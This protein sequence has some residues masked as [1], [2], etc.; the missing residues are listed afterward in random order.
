VSTS[1]LNPDVLDAAHPDGPT[2]FLWLEITSSCQLSCGHCYA[3][4]GPGGSHGAMTEE[5]WSD[6]I[7]SAAESGVSMIQFIG[8][9]PTTHAAF[10]RLVQLALS[11]GL[12]VEVFS[13]LFSISPDGWACL[14]LPG[15]RLATSYYSSSPRIHDRITNRLGS[16]GRTLANI[17]K[18]IE[19]GIPLRVGL[20]RVEDD[21]DVDDARAQLL[22]AGVPQ[23]QIRVDDLRSVG[24][25]A[26]GST[27]VARDEDALCGNCA[28]GVAAILPDGSV[29]PCVFSRQQHFEVGNLLDQT[30]GEVLAGAELRDL[31]GRLSAD[32]T[33]RACA[34]AGGGGGSCSPA[35]GG[36]GP[37]SPAGVRAT[38]RRY[39]QPVVDCGP[40]CSPSCAPVGN[41]NPIVNPGPCNPVGGHPPRP[42]P[43]PRP[44]GPVCNPY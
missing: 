33:A 16:H 8:G 35:G 27:P 28:S 36:G 21:Q 18:A 43:T 44:D 24:R 9:E 15:V 12:E 23:D 20:I 13:N 22:T 25:G 32:F 10:A 2:S 7:R 1:T 17:G 37:C 34:P 29:H 30:L 38:A 26:V 11:S 31:R 41:C 3:E 14:A 19:L 40:A 42:E 6:A 39:G 4:S 5:R